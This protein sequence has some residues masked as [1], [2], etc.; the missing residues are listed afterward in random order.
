VGT[1]GSALRQ[2]GG[3]AAGRRVTNVLLVGVGGQGVL[4]AAR[5]LAEGAFASGLTVSQSEI[6]GMSQRGGS[7]ECQVRFGKAAA[8]PLIP[9]G[10]T[11]VLVALD[12]EEGRR[13]RSALREGGIVVSADEELLSALPHPRTLNVALLGAV[14]TAL[15]FPQRAWR[16]G[17]GR[18]LS[19]R[20]RSMNRQAFAAGHRLAHRCLTHGRK[21]PCE[22]A[23]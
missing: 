17:L 4:T 14:S 7:V 8:G 2:D 22:H 15:P 21:G 18:V 3:K 20:T 5:I 13:A 1:E 9:A 19:P 16:T 12:S 6:H 23:T 11:D 10:Q